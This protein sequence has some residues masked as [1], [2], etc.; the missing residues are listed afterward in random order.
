MALR[1]PSAAAAPAASPG[2]LPVRVPVGQSVLL[3]PGLRG[4]R[5]CTAV[6]EGVA[7]VYRPCLLYPPDAVGPLSPLNAEW[8]VS[9]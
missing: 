3:D 6:L 5:S 8:R 1:L 9:P 4:E 7:R 2:S